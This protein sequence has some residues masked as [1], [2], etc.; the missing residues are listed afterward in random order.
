[1]QFV[2]IC[3]YTV[4]KGSIYSKVPGFIQVKNII[5]HN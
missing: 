4:K 5:K 3:Q 2:Y 1:M